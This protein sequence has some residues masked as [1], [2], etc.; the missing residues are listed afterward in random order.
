MSIVKLTAARRWR[1]LAGS[2]G[3]LLLVA[4]AVPM[5]ALA[6]R[7]PVSATVN[8]SSSVTVAPGAS[9]TAVFTVD[10]SGQTGWDSTGWRISTTP[11]GGVTC[12][13]HANHNPTARY[14]ETFTITAPGT[15]GTYNAYFVAYSND[16]CSSGDSQLTLAGAVVVKTPQ[17]ITFDALTGKTYGDADFTVSATASSGLTVAFSS[18]TTPVCTVSGTDVHIV[19]AGTCEIQADQA[20]NGT[21]LPAPP[22]TRSFEVAKADATIDVTGYTGVYDGAPHGA[23]GTA[24]GVFD[25]DLSGDLDL[26]ATFTS[27]PGGTADWTFTDST[28]NYNNDSG[29]VGIVLAGGTY[30]SLTPARLLD[31]RDGTGLT[32]TFASGVARTFTVAGVGDIPANAVAVTGILTVTNQ[33]SAGF[34][35][36]TP[37]PV[38][39]P[40]TSS[41]NFPV[42]DNRANG[43]TVALSAT[44]SMSA[45]YVG[46]A[47]PTAT[48]DVLFDVTGYF[49][50]DTAG[51]TYVSLTPDR[52]LDTRDG[53]GLT[54]TFASGVA[55]TFTVAGL[56][57]VPADAVAVTG[58]LTVTNQTSRGFISLTPDPVNDPTTSSLNFPVGDNRANGVTVALSA[59]GTLSATYRAEAGPTAT[60]DVLFDVT[61]YF[62]PDATGATY[63][64]LTPARLLDTRD[65]TGLTGTF[66]SGV[67]R[68]FTVADGV[69]VPS[70][71]A[72]VTGNLTATNQTSPGFVSLTPNPVND[73]TTSTL[74]FPVGD[75]RAVGVTGDL[76]GTGTLS[77]TYRGQAGP[78]ATTDLV[79][80]VTGYFVP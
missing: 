2:L 54:G 57:G 38:N 59:T 6:I 33:T 55:R 34:V 73:P 72:A 36:L 3:L 78:T 42:G 69:V 49:V 10:V 71:A 80:D 19:A 27:I 31:T 32:G 67:A 44:G 70:N 63:V 64:W 13:N 25:E 50:P 40:T 47:G 29:S 15:P 14:S 4:L 77:A 18:N 12:V 52:L 75:N 35:A 9:I 22:V 17:T 24:T 62:V 37:D 74:N 30:V 23:T 5:V 56:S 26:G 43:V 20:G 46:E 58:T 45:T 41:L 16:G 68:T 66:A 8:G 21:Y 1:L 39:D 11:P 61:G 65:G 48:T 79:F 51:A 7:T 60:T 76:S 53:T 28:G